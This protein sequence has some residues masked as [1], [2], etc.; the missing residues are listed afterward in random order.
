[1][2]FL[3]PDARISRHVEKLLAMANSSKIDEVLD[4]CGL[5]REGTSVHSRSGFLTDESCYAYKRAVKE[6]FGETAYAFA[7]VNFVLAGCKCHDCAGDNRT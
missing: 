6:V 5:V 4:R 7:K 3:P 2:P 1:M